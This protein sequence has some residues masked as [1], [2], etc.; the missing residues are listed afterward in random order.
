MSVPFLHQL[1]EGGKRLLLDNPGRHGRGFGPVSD[2][3]EPVP[4][5]HHAEGGESASPAAGS[6]SGDKAR[7]GQYQA[8]REKAFALKLTLQQAH[9]FRREHGASSVRALPEPFPLPR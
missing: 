8:R 7:G 3:A 9:R 2:R 4:G 6:Q 1:P 5:Q